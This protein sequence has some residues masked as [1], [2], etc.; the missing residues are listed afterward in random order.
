LTSISQI[1][2]NLKNLTDL[3]QIDVS[4][5]PYN[6]PILPLLNDINSANDI[7]TE[8]D[9]SDIDFEYP[10]DAKF[11]IDSA[12][13][14]Y[15]NVFGSDLA[16][17]WPSE[18]SLSDNILNMMIESGLKWT[19]TDEQVLKNS[20]K[21]YNDLEKYFPRKFESKKGEI[22]LFFRDHSLSDKIGFT[23]TN[24]NPHKAVDDFF[25]E[26]HNIR[27]NIIHKY[28]EFALD[29][30]CVSVILD[31]EN[32]WEFYENLGLE[33]RT[34][35]MS[36]LNDDEYFSSVTMS[37][38]SEK[39]TFLLPLSSIKSGS[40]IN[41]N[42]E[43]WI[44]EEI[45]LKAWKLL[46]TIRKMIQEAESKISKENFQ[47]AM[48][49][50]YKAESSDWFWWYYSRHWAPNKADFDVLFRYNLKKALE[51][52]DLE[53]PFDLS[54]S[55]WSKKELIQMQKSTGRISTMHQVSE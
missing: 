17:M 36:R 55:I 32:C 30:A 42:F 19:A 49:Y 11:Q 7:L 6:H 47:R 34:R 48:D 25:F 27:N 44:G 22:T 12:I 20:D 50:I 1:S 23:Y 28:G 31:G 43:I 3:G 5:S 37:E 10:N 45:H 15:N 35:L 52:A 9:V 46:A 21:S 51:I 2:G 13:K 53:S 26:L 33:F 41:G 38:A 4:F 29:H 54:K 8:L 16:G 40:W 39:N 24:W 18:G 14:K